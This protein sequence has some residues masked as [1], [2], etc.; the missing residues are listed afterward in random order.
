VVMSSDAGA[1][2]YHGGWSGIVTPDDPLPTIEAAMRLYDVRWLALEGAHTVE[3]L[4]PIMRGET[5]PAWLS[6]PIVLT[7][8]RP[9]TEKEVADDPEVEVLPRAALFAVCLGPGDERC[10]T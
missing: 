10:S 1:Y 6:D 7:P 4:R 5:R 9:R 8:P 3:A 2:R